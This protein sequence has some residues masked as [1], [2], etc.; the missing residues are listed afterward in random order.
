MYKHFANLYFGNLDA[1]GFPLGFTRFYSWD[2]KVLKPEIKLNV[3]ML[4]TGDVI[5]SETR[6][7]TLPRS[8][9]V[10]SSSSS[11]L[12]SCLSIFAILSRRSLTFCCKSRVFVLYCSD[13]PH[14]QSRSEYNNIHV[15]TLSA[16]IAPIWSSIAA[17]MATSLEPSLD[18]S[19]TFFCTYNGIVNFQNPL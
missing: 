2:V 7:T 13:M 9:N 17:S 18:A 4:S 12:C 3:R 16:V 14:V 11:T 6:L 19:A 15:H 8:F 10:S 5:E 1:D